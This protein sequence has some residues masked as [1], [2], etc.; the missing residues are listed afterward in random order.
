MNKLLLICSVLLL[1]SCSKEEAQ[2]TMPEADLIKLLY[3]IQVAE[4]AI[5]T[6]HSGSK[7]SVIAIFYDQ[8]Y[9]IHGVN[10][11]I[12]QENIQM[13]KSHPEVSHKIY[14][15]VLEYHKTVVKQKK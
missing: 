10:Q 13:L 1:F 5:Q 11:E 8:I 15:K 2:F 12:L 14:K 7:D 9:E 6:V 4:S 3:D